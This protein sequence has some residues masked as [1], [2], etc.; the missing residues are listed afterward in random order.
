VLI[1]AQYSGSEVRGR[2]SPPKYLTLFKKKRENHTFFL[3]I[4][5][6]T[7][8]ERAKFT[9]SSLERK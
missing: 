5:Q 4:Q 6:F 3:L 2:P 9:L 7:R 1:K 8:K